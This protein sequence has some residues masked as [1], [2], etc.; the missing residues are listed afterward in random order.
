MEE[1]RKCSKR[2]SRKKS[3]YLVKKSYLKVFLNQSSYKR[4]IWNTKFEWSA[5]LLREKF[6]ASAEN[7]QDC[8]CPRMELLYFC[9]TE[10]YLRKLS[11][12]NSALHWHLW[13]L[14]V[15]EERRASWRFVAAFKTSFPMQ[16]ICRLMHRIGCWCSEGRWN[17]LFPKGKNLYDSK[18]IRTYLQKV[19]NIIQ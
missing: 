16:I 19:S 1:A 5:E 17:E 18:S 4:H 2:G 15:V 11:T 12:E 9:H 3:S 8:S 13:R 14:S 10:W 7:L 6:E